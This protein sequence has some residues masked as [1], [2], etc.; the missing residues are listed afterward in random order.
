MTT[1]NA[2]PYADL[3]TKGVAAEIGAE[4]FGKSE[5]PASVDTDIPDAPMASTV[6]TAPVA[7][8]PSVPATDPASPVPAVVPGENSVPA[9]LPKSW[10]KEMAPEWASASPGLKAYVRE[11]EA[12]VMRGINMYQQGY[13]AWDNLIQPFKPV[14]EQN[15]EVN[16]IVLMQ[17]LMA[18]HLQLLSPT[19]SSEEKTGLVKNLLT[20]YGINLEPGSA[21]QVDPALVARL[22]KAEQMIQRFEQHQRQAGVD[23]FKKQVDDFAALPENEFFNEVGT[24]ILRFIQTGTA[25]T[26]KEA[27]DLACWANPAVRAKMIAKQQAPAKPTTEKPRGKNGQFLNIEGDSDIKIKP[28]VGTMDDTINAIVA[29]AYSKH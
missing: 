26:L 2:D 27:Y 9:D 29:K 15:P 22:Q 23:T 14:L 25:A 8:T 7:E 6:E 21:P 24:D 16:P 3:D 18:T 12:Q 1:E 20:Q 28:K 10:K 4:L 17:G 5:T 13:Q 11:R 19:V